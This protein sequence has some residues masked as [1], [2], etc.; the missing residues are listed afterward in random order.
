MKNPLANAIHEWIHLLIAEMIRTQELI[1]PHDSTVQHEIRL[2]LQSEAYA[3]RA[4]T[5]TVTKYSAAE[6]I[7]GRNMIIHQAAIVDSNLLRERKRSQQ[8]KDNL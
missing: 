3:L 6:V 2:L 1:V 5:S 8:V 7:F 4:T